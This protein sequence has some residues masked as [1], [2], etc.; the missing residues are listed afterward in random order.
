MAHKPRRWHMLAWHSR[1]LANSGQWLTT[2]ASGDLTAWGYELN[3]R[4]VHRVWIKRIPATGPA[5]LTPAHL[6]HSQASW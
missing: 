1:S 3:R 6:A 2:Y 4:Y 5:T